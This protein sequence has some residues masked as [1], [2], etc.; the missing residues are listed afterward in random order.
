MILPAFGYY[1]RHLL[2]TLLLH[3]TQRPCWEALVCSATYSF[4]ARSFAYARLPGFLAP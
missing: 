1:L 3:V 4:A 2:L